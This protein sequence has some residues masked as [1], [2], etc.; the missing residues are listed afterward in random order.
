MRLSINVSGAPAAASDLRAVAE[1]LDKPLR[2]VLGILGEAMSSRFMD[3]IAE[4]GAGVVAW[5]EHHPVTTKI[6]E[7]Y[8]HGG[9][10]KLVRGAQL[11]HSIRT[12]DL[13]DDA[14]EVGTTVPHASVLQEG[15]LW[16]DPRTGAQRQVQAF[17]FIVVTEQDADDWAE[18]LA[19]YFLGEEE[20]A[21]A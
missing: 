6:R 15:G 3:L 8:G 16:T 11:L 5:P 17:P 21:R 13:S 1:R 12:L 14:V 20:A 19:D 9:K 2:P 4:E 18:L 7:Y 10:G